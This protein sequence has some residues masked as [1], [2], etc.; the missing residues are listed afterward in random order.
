MN[1][2][3]MAEYATSDWMAEQQKY[4]SADNSFIEQ[5]S[6]ALMPLLE[7]RFDWKDDEIAKVFETSTDQPASMISWREV[8]LSDFDLEGVFAKKLEVEFAR[9]S[10]AHENIS[11]EPWPRPSVNIELW[12]LSLEQD[13][14]SLFTHYSPDIK[15]SA[16]AG[17]GYHSEEYTLSARKKFLSE[18]ANGKKLADHMM[19]TKLKSG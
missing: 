18:T 14:G 3:P 16:F 2:T 1:E 19:V 12:D 15:F 9:I 8:E 5:N 17:N 10:A 4:V 6:E 7:D 13:E 11:I